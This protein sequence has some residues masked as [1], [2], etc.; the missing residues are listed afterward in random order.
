LV[1]DPLHLQATE[2]GWRF[3]NELQALFL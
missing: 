3:L 2:V 1:D